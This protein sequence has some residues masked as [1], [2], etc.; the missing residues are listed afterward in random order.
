MAN[1]A[2]APERTFDG[3]LTPRPDK[4]STASAAAR[5]LYYLCPV[6]L[7]AREQ[8]GLTQEVFKYVYVNL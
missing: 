8:P 1:S 6:V 4:D 3:A 7:P 5:Q 2:P